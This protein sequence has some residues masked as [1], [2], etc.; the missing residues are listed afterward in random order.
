[1]N[2]SGDASGNGFFSNTGAVAGT[3]VVVGLAAAAIL[4]GAAFFYFRRRRANKLD[5]DLRIAAG[6]AGTAGAG[7]SRFHDDDE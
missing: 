4:L 3:F 7:T 5:D 6:G 1:M 2:D